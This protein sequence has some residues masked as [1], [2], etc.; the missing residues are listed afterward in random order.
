MEYNKPY[1]HLVPRSIMRGALPP[2]PIR[3]QGWY[4]VKHSDNFTLI[5]YHHESVRIRDLMT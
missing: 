2:L 5:C 4:V 1:L 3:L